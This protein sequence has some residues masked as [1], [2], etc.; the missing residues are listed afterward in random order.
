MIEQP[1]NTNDQNNE[2]TPAAA[3]SRRSFLTKASVGIVIASMPAKSVWASDGG[4]AQSIVASG[5]G[6]DFAKGKC[7]QLLSHGFWKNQDSRVIPELNLRF[8]AVFG[9]LTSEF[10]KSPDTVTNPILKRVMSRE[11]L[12][13]SRAFQI[14]AM[15]LNAIYSGRTLDGKNIT[16]PIIGTGGQTFR[17]ADLFAKHLYTQA[18]QN[19]DYG[20]KLGIIIDTYHSGKFPITTCT[21]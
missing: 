15:Y 1:N 21:K 4:V 12:Y 19:S 10:V 5:H 11:N 9:P 13:D 8:T 17:T 16:Y 3:N 7:I 14:V 6:S 18:I 20:T 2:S